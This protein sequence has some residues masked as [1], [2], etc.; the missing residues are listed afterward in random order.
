MK[1]LLFGLRGCR[2][3]K[4]GDLLLAR[5]SQRLRR[6]GGEFPNIIYDTF[7][8]MDYSTKRNMFW[9]WQWNEIFNIHVRNNNNNSE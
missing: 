6:A 7:N 3:C 1:H 2:D 4:S 9:K 5:R 8:F